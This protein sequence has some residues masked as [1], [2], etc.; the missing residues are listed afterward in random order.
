MYKLLCNMKGNVLDVLARKALWDVGLDYLHG[1]SHGVGT[2][3]SFNCVSNFLYV[4]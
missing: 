1:T 3:L 2:K 4:L